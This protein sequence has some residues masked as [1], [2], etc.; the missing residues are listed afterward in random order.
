MAGTL[1]ATLQATLQDNLNR[2]SARLFHE[3]VEDIRK[4]PPTMT[5]YKETALIAVDRYLSDHDAIT[6]EQSFWNHYVLGSISYDGFDSL[7]SEKT[8]FEYPADYGPHERHRCDRWHVQGV[9]YDTGGNLGHGYMNWTVWLARTTPTSSYTSPNT[10]ASSSV[11]EESLAASSVFKCLCTVVWPDVGKTVEFPVSTHRLSEA[12][13]VASTAPFS[14]VINGMYSARSVLEARLF[15]MNVDCS[16]E[17]ESTFVRLRLEQ[18]KSR[19]SNVR[20]DHGIGYRAHGCT[21]LEASG[22]FVLDGVSHDVVGTFSYRHAWMHG[23][24]MIYFP[25][26][27]ISQSISIIYM[28]GSDSPRMASTAVSTFFFDQGHQLHVYYASGDNVRQSTLSMQDGTQ[29]TANDMVVTELDHA[30][31]QDPY[32]RRVRFESE[33]LKLRCEVKSN[34]DLLSRTVTQS[35]DRNIE[36]V[37]LVGSCAGVISGEPVTGRAV[38]SMDS[39]Q[40]ATKRVAEAVR[41][42][43]LEPGEAIDARMTEEEED[44]AYAKDYGVAEPSSTQ[45]AYAVLFWVLPVLMF[46]LFT[47]TLLFLFKGVMAK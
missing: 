46:V 12:G 44:A 20:V 11:D 34:G 25:D 14:L 41:I 8:A 37:I 32:P 27:F 45:C 26:G 15:P 24:E 36:Q 6:A 5:P 21:D 31:A 1:Q 39:R 3:W 29:T 9:L 16:N 18:T 2:S 7:K 13:V 22:S 10:T 40:T 30:D 23:E 28:W 33:M 4:S 17:D 19:W 47:I 38:S 42:M 35:G 43:Q